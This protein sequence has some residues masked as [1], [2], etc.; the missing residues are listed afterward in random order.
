M[1]ILECWT[2]TAGEQQAAAP[3]VRIAQLDVDPEH[4][5]SF[6]IALQENA[7]ASVRAGP[8][9]YAL[10]AVAHRDTPYRFILRLSA[11]SGAAC[12]TQPGSS[13]KP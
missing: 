9:V 2:A 13:H 8:G 12:A 7:A 5:A 4:L 3:Y 10:H 1:Q 11:S 6:K